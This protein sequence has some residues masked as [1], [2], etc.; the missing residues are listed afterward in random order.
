[1]FAVR[2]ILNRR[3]RLRFLP[4]SPNFFRFSPIVGKVITKKTK[5]FSQR[6]G[7][8]KGIWRRLRANV[9][10]GD[11]F[12]SP[13]PFQVQDTRCLYV[14]IYYLPT[15][16]PFFRYLKPHDEIYLEL[17]IRFVPFFLFCARAR[18]H[19]RKQFQN[20]LRGRRRAGRK[21]GRGREKNFLI[22]RIVEHPPR[23]VT[24]FPLLVNSLDSFPPGIPLVLA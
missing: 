17:E 22:G 10:E 19:P 2:Y 24:T 8:G 18:E 3:G 5:Y 12:V 15:S 1:M 16:I 7:E 20:A 11:F 21:L 13:P 9:R 4:I 6:E 23:K 14:Y